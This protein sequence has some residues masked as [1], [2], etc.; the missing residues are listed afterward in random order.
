MTMAM[1]GFE[2]SSRNRSVMAGIVDSSSD[3]EGGGFS[4]GM[5]FVGRARRGDKCCL[6]LWQKGEGDGTKAST[7]TSIVWLAMSVARKTSND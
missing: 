2:V 7:D 4:F 1:F 3:E 6:C 5:D